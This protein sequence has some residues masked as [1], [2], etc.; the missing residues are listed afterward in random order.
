MVFGLEKQLDPVFNIVASQR[1]RADGG[2]LNRTYDL[3]EAL[4]LICAVRD[5]L[6]MQVLQSRLL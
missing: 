4:L 1:Q 2:P 3:T 6:D 5:A